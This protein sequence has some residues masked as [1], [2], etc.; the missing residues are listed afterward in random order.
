MEFKL[1]SLTSYG[2]KWEVTDNALLKDVDPSGIKDVKRAEVT[3]HEFGWG[4]GV[5]ICLFLKSGGVKYLPLSSESSLEVGDEVSTD[6]IEILQ[7]ERDGDNPIYRFDGEVSEDEE[8]EEVKPRAN[9]RTR[10]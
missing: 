10:K 8:E 5:S 4:T 9:R 1:N 2:Q 3:S 7:L 6:S